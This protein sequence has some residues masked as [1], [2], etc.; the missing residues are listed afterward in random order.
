MTP[1]VRLLRAG[2]AA[3]V[4][5]GLLMGAASIDADSGHTNVD[6]PVAE[7]S[8]TTDTTSVYVGATTLPA[9]GDTTDAS[10]VS[11][12]SSEERFLNSRKS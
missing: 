11:N 2:G 4:L 7:T 10:S 1:D 6:A 9:D 12:A 8:T 3:L 5:G